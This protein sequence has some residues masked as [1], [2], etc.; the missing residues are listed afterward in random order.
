MLAIDPTHTP[1]ESNESR[2]DDV[3]RRAAPTATSVV[4]ASAV[5]LI[6]VLLT[7]PVLVSVAV[8]AFGVGLVV[9]RQL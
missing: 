7:H 1:L 9:G 8:T 5:L 3:R 4:V 6:V 2:R